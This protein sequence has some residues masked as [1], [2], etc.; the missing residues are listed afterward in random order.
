MGKNDIIEYLTSEKFNNFRKEF[1]NFSSIP[2]E[3]NVLIQVRGNSYLVKIEDKKECR[4]WKELL[5]DKYKVALYIADD[6]EATLNEDGLFEEDVDVIIS[7]FIT[8][9]T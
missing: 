1:N 4:K 9:T 3:E 6:K 5:K 7:T 2:A 8:C